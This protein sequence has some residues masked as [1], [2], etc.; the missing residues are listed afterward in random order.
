M[1]ISYTSE[2]KTRK[3]RTIKFKLNN[4]KFYSRITFYKSELQQM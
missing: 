1:F 4:I 2:G 3:G